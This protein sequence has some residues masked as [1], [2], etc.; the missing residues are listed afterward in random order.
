MKPALAATFLAVFLIQNLLAQPARDWDKSL[1]GNGWDEL[2][3]TKQLPGGHFLVGGNTASQQSGDVGHPT[4]G[5]ADFWLLETNADGQKLADHVFGGDREDKLWAAEPLPDGGWLLAG[6]SASGKTGNKTSENFGKNDF[7]IIRTDNQFNK[8]S[9]WT[10]GGSGDDFLFNLLPTDDGN[11]ILAGFSDS[12]ADGLKTTNSL[13]GFDWWI[14]KINADG[15]ILWQKTMG[16]DGFDNLYSVVE[17]TD[18]GLLFGGST[19]SKPDQNSTMKQAGRGMIDF[20]AVRTDADANVVWENR[21]GGAERDQL[22]QILPLRDGNFLLTGGSASK[23]EFDRTATS[24]G[25]FDFWVLKID[26]SGHEIW[27]K[28]YGGSGFDHIYKALE[29]IDGQLMLAGTSDSPVSGNHSSAGFGQYDFWLVFADENGEMRWNKSYGGAQID[30]VT[31]LIQ[32]NDGD[33]SMLLAGHSMSGESGFHS[34]NSK[35]LN[36]LW[37]LKTFCGIRSELPV[38]TLVCQRNPLLLDPILS[39]CTGGDCQIL[40]TNGATSPTVVVLPDSFSV[41]GFL[42]IDNN[43]CALRDSI[44]MEILPS[45]SLDLGADSTLFVGETLLLNAFQP[46]AVSFGWSTGQATAQLLAGEEGD[47]SVTITGENGCQV[48]DTIRVCPCLERSV[49]IPNIFTPDRNLYND[50]FLVFAKPGAVDKILR[51][52][53]YN[54]AGTPIWTR[55]NFQANDPDLGWDGTRRGRRLPPDVFMYE[56]QILFGNGNTELF[57][58]TVALVR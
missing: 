24:F 35:G 41:A 21:W 38:D 10:Y 4:A 31:D 13:G 3:F 37:L 53:I 20:W 30:A 39:G 11:F 48:A 29:T 52:T 56:A 44:F 22:Q 19:D 1:G 51:L 14:L 43:A 42:A 57:I 27:Q 47:F 12:P 50:R 9:E 18:G 2:H 54:R 55:E 15:D 16:G 26:P 7:W 34:Q 5:Q 25:F 49:Y 36:D 8:I 23:K 28:S 33:F 32:L 40:W 17:T 45:P 6:H 46:D 58:G